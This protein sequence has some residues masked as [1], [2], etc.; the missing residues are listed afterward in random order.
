M[1]YNLY[2][3][4]SSGDIDIPVIMLASD[5]PEDATIVL[6]NGRDKY[7][8]NICISSCELSTLKKKALLGLH[9]FTGCDQVSSFLR[10]GKVTCWKVLEKNPA[11]LEGFAQLGLER[12]PSDELLQNIEEFVC[13][14]YGERKVR[15]VNQAR[16]NIFWRTLKKKTKVIDLSLL[17]PCKLS[18]L[19]HLTRANYVAFAWR[20]ASNPEM[21]I[22]PPQWH[23]W[24]DE[25][26]YTW[27]DEKYPND[28]AEFLAS[29]SS[30]SCEDNNDDDIDDDDLEE[31]DT[32]DVLAAESDDDD[33][34]YI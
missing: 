7:R 19:H 10:K 26:E 18:L 16:R 29:T 11:L 24:D 12:K 20:Q 4:S 22:E 27:S 17:P 30:I 32:E 28:V 5:F 2:F 9:A 31:D 8:K 15:E 21:V 1:E 34:H 3:R 33:H 25:C 14:L 6:D 13:R 23:G